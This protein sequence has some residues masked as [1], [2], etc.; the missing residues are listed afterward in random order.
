MNRCTQTLAAIPLLL[1]FCAFA[2]SAPQAAA[3]ASRIPIQIT[4]SH[5]VFLAN[6][7]A[8]PDF[9]IDPT[10][11]FNDI[12]A[13][14]DA[15]GRYQLVDSPDR[16]DLIFELREAAPISSVNGIRGNTAS[17]TRPAFEVTIRDP[18]SN[19]VLWTVSS[20][21]LLS[22][23]KKNLDSNIRTSEDNL[24]SRLQVLS[25]GR[26]TPAQTAALNTRPKDHSIKTGVIL[27]GSLIGAGIAGG[28]LLHHEFDNSLAN[29]KASQD[30][31]CMAN[32]IPL[33]MCAGG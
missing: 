33:N 7:S 16:A 32:H 31:F 19:A 20:P 17:Y 15:W 25:G 30:A 10:R 2:Q 24:I 18:H 4:Q 21:V 5:S 23:R 1:S 22:G 28:F 9:P 11:A 12:Y 27:F 3:E 6:G 8:D 13:D 26:L 14:L 29:Q